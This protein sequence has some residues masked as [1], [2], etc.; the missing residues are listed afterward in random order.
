V[1]GATY[2][3]FL[4]GLRNQSGVTEASSYGSPDIALLESDKLTFFAPRGY[5]DKVA[6][7]GG[8]SALPSGFQSV[9]LSDVSEKIG[10]DDR[11]R[12]AAALHPSSSVSLSPIEQQLRVFLDELPTL[13]SAGDVEDAARRVGLAGPNP[14][15]ASL[16]SKLQTYTTQVLHIEVDFACL[17]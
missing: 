15:D 10:S 7:V 14:L 4:A 2:V 8:P 13:R 5:L 16:C 6:R 11:L 9:T 1:P 17:N 3:V 12:A